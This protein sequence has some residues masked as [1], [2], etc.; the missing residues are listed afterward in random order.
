[1]KDFLGNE[2]KVGDEVVFTQ[3]NYRSLKRA[4]IIKITAQKV[5]LKWEEE[6]TYID[7]SD[8]QKVKTYPYSEE[9]MQEGRRVI[10]IPPQIP[11]N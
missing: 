9:T 7:Y 5:R 11:K 1:M 6:R 2:L 8:N 3:L 10:L 4:K